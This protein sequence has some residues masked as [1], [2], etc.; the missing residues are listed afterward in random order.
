M[1]CSRKTGRIAERASG[2]RPACPAILSF[3]GGTPMKRLVCSNAH[4]EVASLEA[5]DVEEGSANDVSSASMISLGT[6]VS[7]SAFSIRDSF[8]PEGSR[9]VS[10]SKRQT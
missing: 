2:M 6:S 4:L 5:A 3:I 1:G 8:A 10:F 7:M 9:M